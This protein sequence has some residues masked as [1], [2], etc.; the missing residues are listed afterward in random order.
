MGASG[1]VDVMRDGKLSRLIGG[2]PSVAA[3]SGQDASGPARM[4]WS[5]CATL[6]VVTQDTAIHGPYGANQF[7]R[8]GARLGDVLIGNTDGSHLRVKADIAAYEAAHNPDH[9]AGGSGVA[10]DPYGLTL[11]R[12]GYAV[13]DAAANDALEVGIRG[14]ISLRGVLPTQLVTAPAGVVGAAAKT[15]EVQAVP[16]S[17]VVAPD[18]ALYVSELT[19]YPFVQGSASIWRLSRGHPARVYAG[20]FTNISAMAID[21]HGD[22]FVL[23]INRAGLRETGA[24]GELIEVDA[25]R[26]RTVLASAGLHSPTGV[27]VASDGTIYI[28]NNGSSPASGP[29]PHGEL[30]RV[31]R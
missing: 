21:G 15:V 23:E 31:D 26:G 24:P 5:A 30:V 12:G 13:A 14:S 18:G 25:E 28:A 6:A 11:Y 2:L 4:W 10:S 9:G 1:A 3:S 29:G 27:A 22:L 19:G 7:G 8:F 17:V 16:T 20:G